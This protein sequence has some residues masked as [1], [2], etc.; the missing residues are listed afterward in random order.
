MPI[1]KQLQTVLSEEEVKI[2]TSDIS[3][4]LRKNLAAIEGFD[5]IRKLRN[6]EDF[7]SVP[8]EFLMP[9]SMTKLSSNVPKELIEAGK[10]V[11]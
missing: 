6:L 8:Y 9:F 5:N 1:I 2:L 10:Q 4:K 3:F 11:I 7:S